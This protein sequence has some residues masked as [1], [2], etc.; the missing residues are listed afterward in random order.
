MTL[1]D[2]H[3]LSYDG[4]SQAVDIS[5]IP[6][7]A[8]DRIEI[9]ADGASAIYG[10]DAVAG[11]ANVILKHD[12]DGLS[13][14]VRV[15]QATSDGDFQQQY[16]V[17]GGHRWEGG[18]FIATL[19]YENDAQILASQRDYTSYL[20]NPYSL[21]PSADSRAAL[22]S[23]H[24]DIGT[25]MSFSVDAL[26]NRLQSE[27]SLLYYPAQRSA[28]DSA[29]Y[30]V[31][32]TLTF[33]LPADW[34]ASVNGVY[35]KDAGHT[36]ASTYTTTGAVQSRSDFCYCNSLQSVEA[37]SEGP[38]LHLPGSDLRGAFGGGYRDTA[39]ENYY[40]T[41]DS[42]TGG[43]EHSYYGFGELSVPIVS[44]AQHIVFVDRLSLSIAGRRPPT[45]SSRGPG[46]VHTR[47]L[48]YCSNMKSMQRYCFPWRIWARAGTHPRPRSS[49]I[50][51]A[52]LS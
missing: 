23:A 5:Q 38:L 28:L 25:V 4:F 14:S 18:G 52:I 10:S 13:T 29:S 34:T 47:S 8:L 6:L 19:D 39:F 36:D 17:V 51:A 26:Y 43:S 35:G 37:S 22:L 48:L 50:T 11:V 45:S 9:V 33:K 21:Q 1:L 42:T 46:A 20:P 12:Y 27:S 3:R 30:V 16:G 15:G 32:P 41:E 7:A 40:L 2:G 44:P 24:Q 31:S 49:S